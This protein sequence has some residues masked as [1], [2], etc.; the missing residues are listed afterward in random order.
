MFSKLFLH[1]LSVEAQQINCKQSE[2]CEKLR[3]C[4]PDHDVTTRVAVSEE[5][6]YLLPFLIL[7]IREL[8]GKFVRILSEWA[9]PEQRFA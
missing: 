1:I 5:S 4:S 3:I 2:S 7:N 9:P 8:R 6:W